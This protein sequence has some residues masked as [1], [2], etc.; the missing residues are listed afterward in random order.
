MSVQS[1]ARAALKECTNFQNA[2]SP[3]ASP[4]KPGGA[5]P[6]KDMRKD[7][8]SALGEKPAVDKAEVKEVRPTPPACHGE[9]ASSFTDH[10]Q[11]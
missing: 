6:S 7:L 1:P 3:S 8:V 9:A 2:S 11:R 5:N 10:V 4:L